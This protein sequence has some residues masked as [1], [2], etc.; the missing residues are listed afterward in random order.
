MRGVV[1]NKIGEYE[2]AILDLDRSIELYPQSATNH[3][4]R[5]TIHAARGNNVAALED[6]QT[7]A[8]LAPNTSV[9]LKNLYIMLRDTGRIEEEIEVLDQIIKIDIKNPVAY[10]DRALANESIGNHDAAIDDYGL[11]IAFNS[12]YHAAYNNRGNVLSQ[13]NRNQEAI[14]DLT[15]SIKLLP[16]SHASYLNLGILYNKLS[17]YN[18]ALVV[19]SKA[20][21]IAPDVIDIKRRVSWLLSTAPNIPYRNPE[22]ALKLAK[23][24]TV[25]NPTLNEQDFTILAAAYAESG[26][27]DEALDEAK[28]SLELAEVAHNHTLVNE[29]KKHIEAYSNKQAFRMN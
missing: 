1:F 21:Q 15:Q 8:D 26:L 16:N 2:N 18:E 5:G 20:H 25:N 27:F 29:I 13:L 17:R 28:H 12:N 4:L 10:F 24:I 7:A 9:Y 23:D 14:S 3:Y 22:L 6:F 19:L 11:A